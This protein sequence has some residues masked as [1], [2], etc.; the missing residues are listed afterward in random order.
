MG[1]V[2]D[3]Y[4][5]REPNIEGEWYSVVL[6]YEGHMETLPSLRKKRAADEAVADYKRKAGLED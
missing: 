4:A 3:V 5:V 6:V 2:K 1:K